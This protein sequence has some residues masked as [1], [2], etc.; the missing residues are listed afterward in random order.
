MAYFR[1]QKDFKRCKW[2]DVGIK[3]LRDYP[4]AMKVTIR[5]I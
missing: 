2:R 3:M 5:I 4:S 1:D